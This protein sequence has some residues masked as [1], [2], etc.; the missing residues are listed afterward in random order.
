MIL[1]TKQF[2]SKVISENVTSQNG[3]I[4]HS[5]HFNMFFNDFDVLLNCIIRKCNQYNYQYQYIYIKM[6][7]NHSTIKEAQNTF[8]HL[9]TF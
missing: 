9:L 3:F 7:S 1:K 2:T 8:C 6:A 4:I 5:S